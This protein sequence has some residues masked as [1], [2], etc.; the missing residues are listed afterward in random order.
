MRQSLAVLLILMLQRPPRHRRAAAKLPAQDCA[1]QGAIRAVQDARAVVP[2]DV[3]GAREA[4]REI[5]TEVVRVAQDVQEAVMIAAKICA[6][7]D[8]RADV[9]RVVTSF[10]HLVVEECR[11]LKLG[12]EYDFIK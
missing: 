12:N 2:G 4:V 11:K 1:R 7:E 8:V 5:A 6:K 9:E 3:L 10:V